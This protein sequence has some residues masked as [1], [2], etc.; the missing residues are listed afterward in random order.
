LRGG[1]LA[2][3]LVL[4]VGC[5]APGNKM[6]MRPSGHGGPVRVGDLSLN[7][8]PLSPDLVS[9]EAAMPRRPSDL[10]GLVVGKPQP[11][12]IG[13]E[14]VLLATVWDHPEITMPMGPNR[15]D[16]SSGVLVDE[17]GYIFFPYVGKLKVEGMTPSEVREVL[18][19]RL[20]VVL[21]NPQVDL[22]VI[23]YRSQKVYISGEVRNPAVYTVT[24]VPFTLAEAIN[25]AGGLLPTADDAHIVLNRGERSW[26][27][28]LPE[29]LSSGSM[30]GQ[31]LLKDG[32]SLQVP[33]VADSPVYLMGEVVRPGNVNLTHGRL[34]LARAISEAGGIQQISSD[35]TSIYVIRPTG[36][37]KT[38]DVFHLDARNPAA[39][40]LA[41]KFA[42]FPHDIV[43]V[44]AG[45]LVR[46][47]RVMSLLLPTITAATEA[48]VVPMEIRYFKKNS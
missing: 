39:M 36:S 45:S 46:F 14:D 4:A 28:N 31:I 24:D 18:T 32:D 7:L 42:L 47:N 11:Y 23:A 6:T 25:R 37:P 15:T 19:A 26:V 34:T 35:A 9:S 12:R 44:D 16:A 27:L 2:A 5:Q 29:I 33:N 17:G 3:A 8:R 48:A 38:A 21:R 22:K 20:A 1:L 41:D 43:Y 30:M 10:E 40:V 13:P